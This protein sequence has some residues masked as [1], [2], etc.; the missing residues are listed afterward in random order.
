MKNN[1]ISNN[2]VIVAISGGG[3]TL[4]NLLERQKEGYPFEICGVIA[5]SSKCKGIQIAEHANLPVFVGDFSR[6][7]FNQTSQDLY[8]WISGFNAGWIAL[9]GFLK[10]MP[11]WPDWNNRIVN[12][13]PALLPKFG[14]K[15]MYGHHVHAAVLEAGEKETGATIHFVNE[16]YDEGAIVA[17]T[18]VKVQPD[19]TP[20]ILADRVFQGECKLYPEV[21]KDLI[22]KELPLEG[23]KIKLYEF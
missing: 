2:R 15:G 4:A 18:K 22:E 12:I 13:H 7:K 23:G 5:S 11:V 9:G 3:R 16:K 10:I 21:L 6:E 1:E 14:G 17:Q 8:S 20:E 19:D